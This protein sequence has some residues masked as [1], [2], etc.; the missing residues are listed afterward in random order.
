MN[1]DY[2]NSSL[3][4]TSVVRIS[5]RVI[6]T[7]LSFKSI[8][9]SIHQTCTPLSLTR[10]LWLLGLYD[11]SDFTT[12]LML[13]LLQHY[14]NS[15]SPYPPSPTITLWLY[16]PFMKLRQRKVERAQHISWGHIVS[17]TQSLTPEILLPDN[18]DVLQTSDSD[19]LTWGSGPLLCMAGVLVP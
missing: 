7:P 15:N 5:T 12:N 6:S 16:D 9:I 1:F 2:L 17:L 10:T 11:K 3:T 19:L 13:W 14:D 18:S 8:L 4:C